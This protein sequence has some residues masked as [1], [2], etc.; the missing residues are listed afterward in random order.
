[1]GMSDEIDDVTS[2]IEETTILEIKVT[3]FRIFSVIIVQRE[4]FV[5]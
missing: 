4:N 5:W 2:V 1:M 3:I